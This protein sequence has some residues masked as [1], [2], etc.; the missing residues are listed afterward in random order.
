MSFTVIII[1]ITVIASLT[2][3]SN[4]K[5]MNDLIFYPPAIHQRRQWY[6]FFTS[7][8]LHADYIHLAFNM[9][10]L[11]SFGSALESYFVDLFN[12]YGVWVYLLLYILALMVSSL[13]DYF[14]YKE[15]YHYRSLGASGAVSAVVFAC[16]LFNPLAKISLIIIP[17]FGIPGFVFAI[18]FLVISSYL[19]KRGGGVINHSAHIFGA[20][21]G[22]AFSIFVVYTFSS[23]PL[24]ESF[25]YQI[26]YWFINF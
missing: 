14:K 8:L 23:Y 6:R 10:A 19:N 1:I 7:G 26:K 22:I 17:F 9:L 21:F 12:Q 25:Y 18:L 24:L 11:Y 2:A 5:V 3:F 4:N 13:P 16:I 20:L 15:D